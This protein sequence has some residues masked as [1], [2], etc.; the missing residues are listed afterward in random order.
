M[1]RNDVGTARSLLFVPGDRPDRFA[2]AVASGA[3]AV[4]LDLEDAVAPA[5]K[6]A[7]L[8]H[9]VDFLD[10]LP[11]A[12][13][14]SA[15]RVVVRV[16]PPG[17]ETSQAEL[18]ALA[19]SGAA[20]LV[21]V[22]KAESAASLE[23][24]L[25]ELPTRSGTIPLVETAA[26]L[27]DVREVAAARGVLRLAF[28][29]LDLCAQLGLSPEDERRLDPARLAL[30]VASAAASLPPPVDGVSTSIDD[31]EAITRETRS[32]VASGFTG[33]LCIHPRQV[34]LV[35]DALRPGDA[36]VA[37]ARTVTGAVGVDGV[38]KVDGE[39]VDRPVVIRAEA[40][41]ARARDAVG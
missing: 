3:D 39:F 40:I 35:H 14:G 26:G 28:G 25:D 13:S 1:R 8:G 12:R 11:S 17:S 5:N 23:A 18:S 22:P 30:V 20:R 6:A 37:W 2:K 32:A 19:A 34:S 21:M 24:V 38:A 41:L 36:E 15:A 27:L 16:N 33:R 31:A 10:A 29:H 9:V 7:A 4:V